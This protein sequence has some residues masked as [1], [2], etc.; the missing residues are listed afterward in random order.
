M[1]VLLVGHGGREAALAW[2]IARSPQ[3]TSLTVTGAN[4]GWPGVAR[5]Q[6][7]AG[8][9]GIV[10]LARQV[11]ADVV[12]VGPEAP[13]EAGVADALAAAG[14]PCFG[15]QQAAARLETSKAFAKMIMAEAGV[16]TPGYIE[17]DREDPASVQRAHERI[18]AGKVVVKV[19][20]LAAG[21]GVFVCETAAQ[22]QEALAE[23]WS[24]RFGEAARHLVLEDLI[25]GPEISV[26]GITDGGRVV[27]LPSSQDHKALKEGNRGPNTGGMGAYAPCP[28][29][30]RAAVESI[31]DQVHRPVIRVMAE[32]GTPFR[33]VLFA[34]LMMTE[35]GPKVLE[36]NARFGDP[37]T[38]PLMCLWDDD[39]LTWLAGAA[40]GSLPHGTPRFREGTACCVVLASRGYPVTSEK[41]VVIPEG[42]R[43]ESVVVFHSGTRRGDDGLLRTHGGRVLGITG[44]G[45]DVAQARQRAYSSL[46]HWVFDGAQW[47]T[48]IGAQALA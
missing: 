43:D 31:L 41:G 1:N 35:D 23:A 25:S 48:D 40:E 47:R 13:L 11:A 38:Q 32:R 15:P 6:P 27:G 30:D 34:G 46:E 37:E 16:P 36:F 39:I 26:F 3:L 4:P 29:L 12:V 9:A 18:A 28:L 20:G 22:A 19:D 42:P 8:V 2:R 33:G 45:D 17:V 10:D 21:K 14:V 5:V 44:L 7:T 24:G